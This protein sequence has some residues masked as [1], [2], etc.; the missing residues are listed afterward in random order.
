MIPSLKVV[1]WLI[2]SQ[3][4]VRKQ[5]SSY[6]LF[7]KLIHFDTLSPKLSFAAVGGRNRKVAEAFAKNG[8]KRLALKHLVHKL[9]PDIRQIVTLLFLIHRSFDELEAKMLQGQKLQV[10]LKQI[11]PVLKIMEK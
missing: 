6:L 1:E 3:H 11:T 9:N 7:K 5:I 10:N 8:G 2:L 4:A